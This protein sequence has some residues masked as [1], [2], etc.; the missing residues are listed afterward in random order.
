MKQFITT[1]FFNPRLS[2]FMLAA[3]RTA[4]QNALYSLAAMRGFSTI[5]KGHGYN[6][7]EINQR[8]EVKNRILE[9]ERQHFATLSDKEK[10]YYQAYRLSLIKS[11]E[12]SWKDKNN[13]WNKVGTMTE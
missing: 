8:E 10:Q 5:N 6:D 4:S 13:W 11:L 7:E 2:T 1:A 9:R 12:E 3:Q